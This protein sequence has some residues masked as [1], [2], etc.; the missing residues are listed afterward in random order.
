MATSTQLAVGAA[1]S[2]GPARYI[3]DG[4]EQDLQ[5]LERVATL[6][7]EPLVRALREIGIADGWKALD[8][9]CGPL[10]GLAVLAEMVG[11]TGR[12]V[13]LDFS[14]PAVRRARERVAA[15]G[16]DNV[17]VVTGDIHDAGAAALGGPFDVAYARCFLTHQNDPSSTLTRIAALVRPGGW[18]IAHEP[19]PA[20]APLSH[21]PLAALAACWEILQQA[22][23]Q[24]G[25]PAGAIAGLPVS[26][27]AAGLELVSTE[28]YF[29]PLPP[30][31]GFEL[32]ASTLE[33]ASASVRSA[34]IATTDEIGELVRTLRAARHDRYDWVSTPFLL[35]LTL[36]KP[37]GLP[38]HARA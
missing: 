21:P 20:P 12:A 26:A 9:G 19:L 35:H 15:L 3:L 14:E 2:A 34:G 10:G 13:G 37:P 7:A 32:H 8:C 31:V 24:A 5:R 23:R 30:D 4:S 29:N 6:A 27:R 38:A 16:L 25:V 22:T 1:S 33:A 17:G 11:P 18:I 28:G 36:R